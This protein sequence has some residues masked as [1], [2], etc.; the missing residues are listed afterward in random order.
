MAE[1]VY[2]YITPENSMSTGRGVDI[3]T[4][5]EGLH[6]LQCKGLEDKGKAKNKYQESFADS[7]TLRVYE[8]DSI[9]E[10]CLEPTDITLTLLF[11]DNKNQQGVV[12]KTRQKVYD[13]FFDYVK[14]GRFYYYDTKRRKEA[15]ITLLEPVKPS[16]DNYI[17]STPYIKA[18]FKFK[19]LK[20]CC[21]YKDN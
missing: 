7:D 16:D 4:K 2:F 20:G 19:N 18:D 11:I 12:V 5:F 1:K 3:E 15:Y 6:Y 13:E 21:E 9:D 10:L 14:L 17:G 8:P